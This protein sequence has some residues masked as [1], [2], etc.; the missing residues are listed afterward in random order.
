MPLHVFVVRSELVAYDLVVPDVPVFYF[1]SVARLAEK[2]H[3]SISL[4]IGRMLEN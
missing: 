4:I 2:T 3:S 1:I